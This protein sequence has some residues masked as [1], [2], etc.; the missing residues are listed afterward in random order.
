MN[1]KNTKKKMNKY[2]LVFYYFRDYVI[3]SIRPKTI[4]SLFTYL[5]IQMYS[6]T[7]IFSIVQLA[8]LMQQ[9]QMLSIAIHSQNSA[10]TNR[11]FVVIIY[12]HFKDGLI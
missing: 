1:N 12:V 9:Q 4:S 6:Q 2:I 10:R 11:I 8:Q 7:R 5:K 3:Y